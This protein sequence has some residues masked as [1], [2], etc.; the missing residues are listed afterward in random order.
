MT[1]AEILAAE[2]EALLIGAVAVGAAVSWWASRRASIA[3][4]H[5]TEFARKS[6]RVMTLCLIPDAAGVLLA[7]VMLWLAANEIHASALVAFGI[8]LGAWN[9]VGTWINGLL[10]LG[11]I[12]VAYFFWFRAIRKVPDNGGRPG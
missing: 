12:G 9:E 5:P 7:L 10:A 6:Q 8:R 11:C 3:W 4:D 2:P 1:L